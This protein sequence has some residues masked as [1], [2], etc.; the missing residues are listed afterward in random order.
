MNDL[1]RRDGQTRRSKVV[2]GG[3]V[4][5]RVMVLVE[6][7][8]GERESEKAGSERGGIHVQ[9]CTMLPRLPRTCTLKIGA[10]GSKFAGR[11]RIANRCE[12]SWNVRPDCEERE[13]ERERERVREA[14]MDRCD[15]VRSGGEAASDRK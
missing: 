13:R 6:G 3:G 10:V 15:E 4:C 1:V 11:A 9:V 12:R 5:K 2:L 7:G 8:G 14:P